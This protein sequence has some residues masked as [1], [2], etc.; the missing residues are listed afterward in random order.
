M[1]P[2]ALAL[3]I[4][5][6]TL[7]RLPF[8]RAD[9]TDNDSWRQCDTA[10]IARNFTREPRILYPR[11]N[12]GAPGPGYVETEFQLYPFF[13]SLLYRLFGDN[14]LF[15]KEV[16]IALSAVCGFVFFRV[17]RRFLDQ[18]GSFLA[19]LFFSM[20][21][22]V[23]RFSRNFMPDTTALLFYL[24]ALERFLA[25]ME[26]DDWAPLL[27]SAAAMALA[28]LVKPTSIH[29]GLVLMILAA[30]RRGTWLVWFRPKLLAFAL[31]SLTPLILFSIHGARLHHDYGNT[32]GTVSGGDPKWGGP[33]WWFSPRFYE[34]LLKIDTFWAVGPVGAAVALLAL[35]GVRRAPFRVLLIGWSVTIFLY[36]LIVARYAEFAFQYHL[37]TAPLLALA[38]A[39]GVTMVRRATRTRWPAWALIVGILAYQCVK[40]AYV[41]QE[42]SVLLRDAG[43][44]LAQVSSPGDRV[45]VLSH[46]MEIKDNV[47]NNYQEPDVFFHADRTGRSLAEDR[48]TEQGLRTAISCGARFFVNFPELNGDA[49]ADFRAYVRDHFSL[50]TSGKDPEGRFEIYACA[51]SADA[52]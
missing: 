27:A 7:L 46:D 12:W 26:S 34:H 21:P 28:L 14:P 17:A 13:V 22:I 4:L 49:S 24:I 8:L 45:V 36:Y 47:P 42:R 43:L 41:V 10:T 31:I 30:A 19:T 39:A 1:A 25:Y 44:A 18:Q 33:R 40:D 23:F 32:F 15:G 38:A 11:I 3:A 5:F 51:P 29:L 50:I 2:V 9:L 37:F 20:A 16:S 52:R 6:M 35:V 48:Q